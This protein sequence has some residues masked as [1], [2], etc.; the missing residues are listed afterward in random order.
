MTR[1]L[2]LAA[3][4]LV[5]SEDPN[6]FI[7]YRQLFRAWHVALA[8]G[9]S[10]ERYVGLVRR[11]DEAVAG[12]DGHGFRVTQ[13]TRADTLS[14]EL[15]FDA[16]GGVWIKDETGGVAGSHKARHLMGILLEILVAEALDP[17]LEGRPLAIASCSN[18]ALAAAVLA[19]AAGR[20]LEVFVPLDAEPATLERLA[21]LG[22]VLEQ[23]ARRAGETG[24]PTVVRLRAALARGAIPFTCQGPE[25]GLT[26]EG[27]Q[28]LGYELAEALGR[29]H[30]ALDRVV[31]QVGG[32]ALASALAQGLAESRALGAIEALPRLD[33]VQT[34]G[35]WPLRR[36]YELVADELRRRG[37]DPCLPLDPSVDPVRTVLADAAR[38][39][40]RYMW[41]WDP[42]PRSL[43]HGILD[44][45][46]YDWLAVVEAMLAT[47]GRPLVVDEPVLRR[48]AAMATNTTGI[49]A[50]ETGAAGLAGVLKLHANGA[51]QPTE[52]LAVL[53]TGGR[54]HA[55]PDASARHPQ[56]RRRR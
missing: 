2:N 16:I 22:A 24:D 56:D 26:I 39:R 11:A 4:R 31:V 52:R 27:G 37:A 7:R 55:E 15:G 35:G 14:A 19:R 44:D 54:H 20:R 45:E 51:L 42:A 30:I 23:A 29:D 47:G 9:W 36:A 46:T 43:A 13:I 10:D 8:A 34:A 49:D 1:R 50:D 6:P 12:V 25:N 33:T 40:S 38:H 32:G 21:G 53:L 41:P 5:A 48:A 3:V 28:T 17:S 18:A